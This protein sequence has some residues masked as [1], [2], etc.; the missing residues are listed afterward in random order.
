MF[1]FWYEAQCFSRQGH[2]WAA[3]GHPC[4][5]MH[6][7][8]LSCPVVEMHTSSAFLLRFH[9]GL[10]RAIG[11]GAVRRR[12]RNFHLYAPRRMTLGFS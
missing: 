6:S 7:F 8:D 10:Q 1:E 9:A 4:F 11:L 3:L 5:W 2:L 12:S